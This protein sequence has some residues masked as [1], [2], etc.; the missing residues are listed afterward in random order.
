MRLTNDGLLKPVQLFG[1]RW[2]PLI[3][4][5]VAFLTLLLTGWSGAQAAAAMVLL[6]FLPGWA[7]LEALAAGPWQGTWRTIVAAGLSFILT[8]LGTL[9]LV[10]LPGPLAERHVLLLSAAITLPPL[11]IAL[12]RQNPSL[13]WP[14]RR[15]WLL[16]I[17]VLL[18]AA[19]IRLPRLGYAE[20]HEDEVEVTTLAGRAISGEDYAVFL[21]RKGPVQSLVPLAG[22]LLTDRISEGWARLPFALASLLGVL[23]VTLLAH[24]IAG[25]WGGLAAGLLLALNGYFVAF[26]R[27]VQYQALIFFLA[28]LALACLWRAHEDGDPVWIWPATLG[29]GVSMLAHYDA[30]VY[31]P[32]AAYLGWR[33]W[34]RWPALRLPLSASSLLALAVLLSFYV[35]YVGDPQFEHTRAYLLENRVGT[36]WLYNNLNTLTRLDREYSSRF[37]LPVLWMLTLVVVVRY[38]LSVWAWWIVMGGSL[39]AAWT[40]LRW[41]DFWELGGLDLSILP[42]LL[43]FLGGWI[44]LRRHRPGFESFW[45][46]WG[47]P[48]LAYVFWVNDPRTHL[49][50]V[51][52]GWAVVAALG[53]DALRHGIGQ[54]PRLAVGRPIL[55]TVAVVLILLL[56]SYQM[57]IF[58]PT[59]STALELRTNWGQTLGQSVYGRLPAP[60]TYFGYPWR[61]GWKATG[62]LVD[63][64][65]LPDDYRSAGVEF[66]VP[67]WYTFGRPRSCYEDPDL[68]LIA[69][70]SDM[71]DDNLRERLATQYVSA[72]TVFSEGNPRISAY[73]KGTDSVTTEAYDLADLE[74][75]FDQA[76]S[77]S[78]FARGTQPAQPLEAQFGEVAKLLGFTVSD[79]QVTPGEVLSVHLYWQS[80]AETDVAYRAFIHLGENPVWGQHDDD[81]ACRLPTT[82]W[83]VGQTTVGQFRIIP[84]PETPPGE[85]PLVIGLYDP[86]TGDRLPVVDK[87]G[88]PIGDNLIL[89]TIRVVTS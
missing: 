20:F 43:L 85:H 25:W 84:I 14:D 8:C 29:L 71:L 46:W 79:Q 47:V 27:M 75:K 87:S 17:V 6:F 61:D 15:L 89:T 5:G 77:P 24:D 18:L 56:A 64:G 81:P 7:W 1:R 31:L 13:S 65:H 42:W 44:G 83:R 2:W 50:V 40:T 78:R 34:R 35:P 51:Y 33:I 60:R 48:L 38:R 39:V 72:A 21:H 57:L 53:A 68:Y 22:W 76:A 30:L 37:Y 4:S 3:L 36:N 86:T 58:L 70:S 11:L 62:W 82:L 28:S 80:L 16:L 12:R 26:G 49:Y 52:P 59:E 55:A 67:I 9:Y 69:Q 41:P 10:Y 74:S 45:I 66:S 73:V 23:T 88:Q 54:L 63:T 32:A 19:A